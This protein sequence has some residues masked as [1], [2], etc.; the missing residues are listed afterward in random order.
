[1]PIVFPDGAMWLTCAD[2]ARAGRVSRQWIW[3]L[4]RRGEI[5]ASY[6]VPLGQFFIT[7]KDA[8]DWLWKSGRVPNGQLILW[9]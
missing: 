6:M 1:M 3:V 4:I 2:L 8:Q 9:A 7:P 5:K